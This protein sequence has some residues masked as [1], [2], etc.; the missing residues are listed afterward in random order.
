MAE[1]LLRVEGLKKHFAV[2]RKHGLRTVR[3]TVHA[4]DGID[5][6]VD[7]GETVGLVVES[8]CGK[9]TAGRAILHLIRPTAGR[10]VFEGRDLSQL[11]EREMRSLRKDMSIVFQDPMSALDPRMMVGDIVTEP[12]RAHG[13][14]PSR[15]DR[16]ARARTLLE[17][18]GLRPEFA[19]RYPHEFSGG[20]RQRIGIARAISTDP[21]LLI[22]DEPISA[23]DISVRAQILNL[24]EDLQ[25]QRKLA[26]LFIA[27]DLS[28][29]RHTCDRVA[30]MYLGIIAE[31][32]PSES[33]FA[34]PLHPYTRA[35][36]ASVP[37]PDPSLRR[38]RALL[39]GDVPTPVAIP[40]G[41]RFRTRCPL[42][43]E[44]CARERPA[45]AP[46]DGGHLAACHFAKPNPIP[47]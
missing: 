31:Q 4:V 22:L 12:L 37:V 2:S 3:E 36:L 25:E 35:L 8:G 1:P 17:Q 24:L 39:E 7:E 42:A 32:G 26:Y 11:S 14:A 13:L 40:S 27:H 33:L 43:Q 16:L 5:L 19:E 29:V 10:V 47:V 41:C 38:E 23:L 20:Q 18:V 6:T 21:K 9:S 44:V 30:V 28:V 15:R 45:L 34:N 46:V